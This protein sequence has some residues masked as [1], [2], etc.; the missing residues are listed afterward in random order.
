MTLKQI[1]Q[2][3]VIGIIFVGFTIAWVILG[4]VNAGRTEGQ[5]SLLGQRVQNLYGGPLI[6]TPPRVYYERSKERK[7]RVAGV[8]TVSSVTERETVDPS[9]SNVTIDL[10]LDRKRVGNLWFPVFLAAY[11]GQYTYDIEAIPEAFRSGPLLLVPGLNS[12][13]SI[14]RGIE[15]KINDVAVE[16]LAKLISNAAIDLHPTQYV[17][18]KLVVAFRYET[19]GTNHLLYLLSNPDQRRNSGEGVGQA[20][21]VGQE[22]LTRVDD[23]S[24]EV[25]TNFFKY[26]FPERTIPYTTL[27][28]DKGRSIFEWRFDQA[29]TGKNIG[30][31][32][33]E[34]L[35][36]GNIASRIAF[37]AP[38]SLLF[39]FVVIMI[40]G[41]L[42]K[43]SLH[44]MHY[45]L[46]SA[47]F[48]SFHLTFSY[49][50]DHLPMYA[51]FAIASLVSCFLTFSYVARAK[52]QKYATVATSL[53]FLYLVVFS[54]SFFYQTDT[55]LGITGLIVTIVSVL[56]LFALMHLTAKLDWQNLRLLQ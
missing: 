45:A 15:F 12:S 43:N 36:P 8:E 16:P 9:S 1:V 46:L 10:S 7:V 27:R 40:F 39:F 56:T 50:A 30:L 3:A 41:I 34:E 4:A 6:V 42:A 31:V 44:P 5:A 35:N 49:S 26:T 20:N 13:E 28:Q 24:L 2:L 14:F 54:W 19:T 51:A 17:D 18:G 33:P 53:Q 29:V 52:D 37:F 48:L 21:A 23:F 22:R 32:I 55:G 11:Q 47:S 38:V 25:T